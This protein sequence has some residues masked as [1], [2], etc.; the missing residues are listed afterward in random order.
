M[1]SANRTMSVVSSSTTMPPE[2]SMLPT[3]ASVS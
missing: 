2:P 3:F 1:R